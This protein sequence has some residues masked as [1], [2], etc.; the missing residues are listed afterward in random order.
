MNVVFDDQWKCDP[1]VSQVVTQTQYSYDALGR[2]VAKLTTFKPNLGRSMGPSLGFTQ[3]FSYLVNQDKILLSK[4]G[5][6]T[7][8]LYLD[9]HG[10]DEHLGEV[11]RNGT[12]AFLTDH[13]GSV[14]NSSIS[15]SFQSYD[16]YGRTIAGLPLFATFLPSDPVI[17]GFAGRQFDIESGKYYNRARMYDPQTGRF[18]NQDPIGLAG[19]LNLYRYA[20]NNS[21][22]YVDPS[23]NGCAELG[24]I[25][26]F[27]LT[28][29]AVDEYVIYESNFPPE[30]YGPPSPE[31]YGPPLSSFDG[32][33]TIGAPTTMAE[34]NAGF[35]PPNGIA[36]YNPPEV[37]GGETYTQDTA[38]GTNYPI[39]PP[40]T[41]D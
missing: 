24:A 20:K 11:S 26:L 33:D 6:G 14:L 19:G 1:S 37:P 13:L 38:P 39:D 4:A 25:S 3:A 17:Y 22:R 15:G 31:V 27:V 35:F 23:G 9:G 29:T 36:R 7:L 12:H 28:L 18:M 16:A 2:R 10:I 40:E 5:D 34:F 30:L 21:L 8:N 32:P 41:A